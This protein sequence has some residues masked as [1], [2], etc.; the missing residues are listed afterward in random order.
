[1]HGN[2]KANLLVDRNKTEGGKKEAFEVVPKEASTEVADGLALSAGQLSDPELLAVFDKHRD[3]LRAV[4][5]R[6]AEA[7]GD[8]EDSADITLRGFGFSKLLNECGALE[9][10]GG[11]RVAYPLFSGCAFYPSNSTLGLQQMLNA[12]VIFEPEFFE[13]IAQIAVS[14]DKREQAEKTANSASAA[15][16]TAG[17]EGGDD[18]EAEGD[19]AVAADGGGGDGGAVEEGATDGAA[20]EGSSDAAAASAQDGGGE[21]KQ[22]VDGDAAREVEAVGNEPADV[23]DRFVVGV[24]SKLV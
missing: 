20:E 12:E 9:K 13:R 10:L 18:G 17:A 24:L 5:D 22:G 16:S 2:F 21:I 23:V 15:A 8:N 7:S 14:L 4:Y 3:T 1:M 11:P 6:F 19:A